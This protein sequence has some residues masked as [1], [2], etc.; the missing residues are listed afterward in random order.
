MTNNTIK[1]MFSKKSDHWATPSRLYNQFINDGY[2]DPCPLYSETDNL[3]NL[4]EHP[5]MFINPPYSDINSWIDFAIKHIN[6]KTQQIIMLVPARTDTKWFH[7]ALH[8]GAKITFIKGRL[9]FNDYGTA[10]FPSI[11]LIFNK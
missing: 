1:L 5:Y 2:F 11:Y 8:N 4:Y 7:K 9:K 6:Y 10:P 3:N